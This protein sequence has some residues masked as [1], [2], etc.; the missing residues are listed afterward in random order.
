MVVVKR[1]C[2]NLVSAEAFDIFSQR[3]IS[4][5]GRNSWCDLLEDSCGWSDCGSA[6]VSET[7]CQT[8]SAYHEG[9][10]IGATIVAVTKLSDTGRE[11]HLLWKMMVKHTQ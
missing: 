1:C 2:V 3:E 8:L 11:L 4:E 7:S 10:C 6:A 9:P 5:S